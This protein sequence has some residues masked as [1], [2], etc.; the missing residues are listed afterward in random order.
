VITK[1][2][3][4]YLSQ[5]SRNWRMCQRAQR[6]RS[7]IGCAHSSQLIKTKTPDLLNKEMGERARWPASTFVEDS[8]LQR[9]GS[10]G[11]QLHV[12]EA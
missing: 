5:F 4:L 1:P 11:P 6:L 12:R 10:L 8:S 7:T 3:R 9:S 2:G